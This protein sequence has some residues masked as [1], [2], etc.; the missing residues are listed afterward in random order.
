MRWS[1]VSR[2]A[3]LVLFSGLSL[4][5]MSGQ[6]HREQPSAAQPSA[7][8]SAQPSTVRAM[9]GCYRPLLVFTPALDNPQLVAQWNQLKDHG[10]ELKSR[11]V[12]YVP[13]VPEGHNQPILNTRIPTGRLSEDDLAAARHRFQVE[14]DQF[15]VVLI[16]KD[17]GQKLSSPT[18][19]SFEQLRRLI[20]SMPKRQEE[21][22]HQAVEP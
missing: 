6:T 7:A 20:D 11:L 19:V 1:P 18:P 14:P 5:H 15:L 22:Q 17:G 8:C 10:A 2:V 9:R 12:M 13:I 4:A 3:V 16:G 21:M